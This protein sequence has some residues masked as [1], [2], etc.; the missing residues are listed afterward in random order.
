V[1]IQREVQVMIGVLASRR[2]QTGGFQND[3]QVLI[4]IR[5]RRSLG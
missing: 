2:S 3:D 1:R 4:P 5:R